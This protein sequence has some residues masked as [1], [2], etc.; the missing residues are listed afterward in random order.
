MPNVEIEY[1]IGDGL[2]VVDG[3]LCVDTVDQAIRNETRPITSNAVNV[4]V[5][6]LDALLQTV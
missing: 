2:K 1:E 3:R 6:N 5:G 4:E